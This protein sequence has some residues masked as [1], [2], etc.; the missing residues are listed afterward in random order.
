VAAAGPAEAGA[1]APDT[2]RR[3]APAG[4]VSAESPRIPESGNATRPQPDRAAEEMTNTPANPEGADASKVAQS[5]P[6]P[7]KSKDTATAPP[8]ASGSSGLA[9]TVEGILLRYNP[10]KREWER[11]VDPTPLNQPDRLLCL[12]PFRA[13]IMLGKIR[14]TLV[15]ET[16]I[17][18]LSQAADPVPSVELV[19]G[20]LLIRQ[21]SSH[22]LKIVFSDRTA[23]LDMP[24]DSSL[25]LERRESQT[26]G[27]PITRTPPLAIDC[28]QGDVSLS[29]DQSHQ[30]LKASEV[31]VI[32]SEGQITR[33]TPDSLPGWV[34]QTEASPYELQVRDQFLHLF[35]AGRPVLAEVVA[36]T[37]DDRA[38]IKRLA[39]SALEALGDLSLLMPM[40]SRAGD[41]VSRRSAQT[42][43]RAFMGRGP[44]AVSRV[45]EQLDEE[46]GAKLGSLAQHMLIG[47][48]PEEASNRDTYPRLVGLLSPEQQSVGIRELALDTLKRLTGRDDLGYDPDHPGGKGLEAWNELLRRNELRP[49]APRAKAKG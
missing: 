39:V 43:I 10:E 9:E 6:T 30:S 29:V 21:P 4:E 25:G 37:E 20:R 8:V 3:E 13:S 31:A 26:Y 32:D 34:T 28:I 2:L 19:E 44:D 22:A 17:R 49:L 5:A 16:E 41:P 7:A 24:P 36:A 18:I 45:R 12:A 35:H 38:D 47:F 23:S 15:G 14:L 33:A 48:S 1:A 11:L 27:Q 42:A 46:F 40:L